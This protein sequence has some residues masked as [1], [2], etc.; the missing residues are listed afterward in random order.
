[1]SLHML[2]LGRAFAW[3]AIGPTIAPATRTGTAAKAILRIPRCIMKPPSDDGIGRRAKCGSDRWN[4]AETSL[5]RAAGGPFW[6]GQPLSARASR[7]GRAVPFLAGGFQAAALLG[8]LS[9]GGRRD[10]GWG[11]RRPVRRVDARTAVVEGHL[12]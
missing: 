1:M 5:E 3:P 4:G 6:P 8:N 11:L 12:D 10:F 9:R 7:P 2:C